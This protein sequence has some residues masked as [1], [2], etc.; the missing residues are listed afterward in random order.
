MTKDDWISLFHATGD[1]EALIKAVSSLYQTNHSLENIASRLEIQIGNLLGLLAN[2]TAS[3]PSFLCTF[4]DLSKNVYETNQFEQLITSL[5]LSSSFLG[6]CLIA[7]PIGTLDNLIEKITEKLEAR[8][9]HDT[10]PLSRPIRPSYRTSPEP[11]DPT[12]LPRKW[13][14]IVGGFKPFFRYIW[15]KAD[16]PGLIY[17]KFFS[18]SRLLRPEVLL[19]TWSGPVLN[20]AN[21]NYDYKGLRGANHTKRIKVTISNI[22]RVLDKLNEFAIRAQHDDID[23]T[24][25]SVISLDD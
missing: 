1:V 17:D 20:I 4:Y 19:E 21:I 9:W 8:G 23:A 15:T 5:G 25:M 2:Y 11:Q 7:A 12:P 6:D 14:G 13:G 18:D 16:V 24:G 10:I 22:D 3:N